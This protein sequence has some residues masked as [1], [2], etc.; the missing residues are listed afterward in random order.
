[1]TTFRSLALVGAGLC[2][3]VLSTI[4]IDAYAGKRGGKFQAHL[5]EGVR[6]GVSWQLQDG[7]DYH[8]TEPEMVTVASEDENGNKG[9]KVT[10]PKRNYCHFTKVVPFW[11]LELY[12]EEVG[13]APGAIGTASPNRSL[14]YLRICGSLTLSLKRNTETS[15][16]LE[17]LFRYASA[18]LLRI[19]GI[20]QLRFYLFSSF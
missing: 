18:I 13:A 7:V 10:T 6:K 12:T 3:G 9:A 4:G 19:I 8:G 15:Y 20:V 5:E 2:A 17:I 14:K 16:P 11:Q 1:M